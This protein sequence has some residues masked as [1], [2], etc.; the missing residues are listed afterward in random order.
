VCFKNVKLILQIK[1]IAYN[2]KYKKISFWKREKQSVEV[3]GNFIL[4]RV[5]N[6]C[7]QNS[8]EIS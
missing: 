2:G 3:Q 1:S 5:K 8:K 6:Y 4:C 7:K